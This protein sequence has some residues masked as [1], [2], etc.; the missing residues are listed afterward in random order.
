MLKGG[1]LT[2]LSSA[3]RP[4]C[5]CLGEGAAA[6]FADDA[7]VTS[8]P[9]VPLQP[10]T[11]AAASVPVSDPVT[12]T[13]VLSARSQP[14]I[15]SH[16]QAAAANNSHLAATVAAAPLL[17][18]VAPEP[19]PNVPAAAAVAAVVQPQHRGERE[20]SRERRSRSRSESSS[21]RRS[22]DSRSRGRAR[23]HSSS[24]DDSSSDD[25]SSRRQSRSGVIGIQLP[26]PNFSSSRFCHARRRRKTPPR[27]HHRKR[28]R[29]RSRRR[30]SRSP[31]SRRNSSRH[32][33]RSQM[34]S[35][36]DYR[37]SRSVVA[38]DQ[39]DIGRYSGSGRIPPRASS[40][41]GKR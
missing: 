36:Q 34:S 12:A 33:N 31:F 7:E 27:K 18:P 16:V 8:G 37:S 17:M 24:S 15:E 28:S 14:A 41:E 19:S 29:S 3:P 40:R 5:R 11:G 30:S 23:R 4:S 9:A 35:R 32:E 2:N 1:C 39:R 25:S 26:L 22:S 13:V 20:R 10:V 38:G 21:S 6:F